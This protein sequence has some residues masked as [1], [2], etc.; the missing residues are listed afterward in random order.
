[1]I[2]LLF[3]H[4]NFTPTTAM[5]SMALR[6]YLLGLPFA[7]VDFLLNYTFYARQD[8]RTPAIVGVIA[9]GIYFVVAWTLK[10][11]LGFLGLV[12]ADSVK[13]AGHAVIM[14]VL[15]VSGVGRPVGHGIRRVTLWAA[16]ASLL[17]GAIVAALAV[18]RSACCLRDRSP[19]S[20]RWRSR[21]RSARRLT[22]AC[23]SAAAW[24]RRRRSA[25]WERPAFICGADDWSVDP[26]TSD[27]DAMRRVR[28]PVFSSRPA[29]CHLGLFRGTYQYCG[30][31]IWY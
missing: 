4:G 12:L 6:V 9:V 11:P 5:T 14:A 27:A 26:G 3:Q 1:V 19:R 25:T 20:S 24:P 17:M 29:T 28:R 15:L 8:T 21:P 31:L 2:R 13:Q 10:G 7:G 23:S 18:A 30:N 22:W 16:G